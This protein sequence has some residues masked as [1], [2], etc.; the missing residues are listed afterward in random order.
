MT[1]QGRAGQGWVVLGCAGQGRA[2]HSRVG[3]CRA[4][5]GKA[6]QGQGQDRTGKES[7]GQC[8]GECFRQYRTQHT[9]GQGE[10]CDRLRDGAEGRARR[11]TGQRKEEDTVVGET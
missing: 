9:A 8:K 5:Q 10:R 6:G 2:G 3:Q 11:T 4:G 1:W 7:A